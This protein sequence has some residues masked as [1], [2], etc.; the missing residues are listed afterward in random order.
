MC[1]MICRTVDI[2]GQGKGPAGWITLTQAHVA[3]DHPVSAPF[4]H[5]LLL[6]FVDSAAGPG[7]RVIVELS[8]D[9]A[10]ALVQAIEAALQEAEVQHA[11][12]AAGGHAG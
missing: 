4:D 3:Y 9:A 2:Q 6:D 1:T 8:P 12:G 7:A 5:A 11:L 10:R